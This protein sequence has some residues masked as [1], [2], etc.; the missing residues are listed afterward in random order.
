MK[1]IIP[2]L[3]AFSQL[4]WAGDP[5]EV[6]SA[7]IDD[8][9]K[10]AYFVLASSGYVFALN[11]VENG[12]VY[13]H[14][15]APASHSWM[16]IGFGSSMKDT[17][18]IISYVGEDGHSLINSPRMAT[19]HSEP[20]WEEDVVIDPVRNDTYAPF[21]NTLSPDGI[22]IS[23]A[24]CRNCSSWA[25]GSIDT[26]SKT[27]PF[28]FALGPNTTLHSND[29]NAPLRLHDFHGAFQLDMTVATNMSGWYGRVPAPQDPGLQVGDSYWAFANYFS[30]NAYSTGGD[31]EWAQIVHAVFMCLAFLLVFPLGAVTLRLVR[32][33]PV[34]AA[35]QIFGLGLVL[36]G[37]ALGVYASKL[38]NKSKSFNSA[39]QVIG[40]VVFAAIFL[41]IGLGLGHHIIFMRSGTST[42]LG[43]VHRF[44]GISIL[45][46]GIVNG[47]IGLDFAGS[48]VVG[49]G[50]AVAIMT[51]IF[52]AISA[53]IYFY[54]RQH[55]Y[56]P[57]NQPIAPK[58]AETG[59]SDEYE[60]H[61]AFASRGQMG[62]V[63]TPRT[64]F[65]GNV[66]A[67]NWDDDPEDYRTY[68]QRGGDR[69][70]VKGALERQESII[71]ETP[72]SDRENPFKGKWEAVPLR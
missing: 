72:A 9:A 53:T 43:K 71:S 65:F 40:L 22:M 48:S 36:I 17:R 41:Q 33:A 57:E 13:F 24:V 28:I 37:L 19:G 56:K 23:H 44:L 63:Q 45:V 66:K 34:H 1:K 27:Q 42:V 50:I 69:G 29:L 21:S 61:Q 49:Y 18:M 52:G 62:Y 25:T 6:V 32:R 38:Y 3:L 10:A 20:E 35:I 60:M 64:P 2:T 46:L 5:K 59:P 67:A 58:D 16:G 12:D 7:G 31:A 54:N 55:V 15:N 30:S 51:V 47:G 11:V 8:H 70:D 39:H 26:T 4:V 14:M 68:V